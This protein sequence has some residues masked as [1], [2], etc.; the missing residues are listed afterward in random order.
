MTRIA[1]AGALGRMGTMVRDEARK[2]GDM[3]TVARFGKRNIRLPDGLEVSVP[4]RLREVLALARPEVL[5]DFTVPSAAVETACTAA[6]MGVNLVIGTTGF[7]QE[8]LS[9]MRQ[10]IDGRVA[11]VIFPNFSPGVNLFWKLLGVAAQALEDYDIEIIEAHHNQ[12]K[13]APSGT[14]MA[15]WRS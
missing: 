9:R 2:A 14:A 6:D 15:Q 4:S 5:I 8:Q 10:A 13:D 3:E 12:K 7:S 1:I 11:A